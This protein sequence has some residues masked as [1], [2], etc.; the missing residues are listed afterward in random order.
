[1]KALVYN[2]PPGITLPT[3]RQLAGFDELTTSVTTASMA[4]DHAAC[5]VASPSR[6]RPAMRRLP[7]LRFRRES[8]T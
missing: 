3:G 1:M 4:F 5:R 8:T 6:P 7:G 2:G